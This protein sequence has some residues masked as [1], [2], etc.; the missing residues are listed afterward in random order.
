MWLIDMGTKKFLRHVQCNVKLNLKKMTVFMELK[1][2]TWAKNTLSHPLINTFA[3][4]IHHFTQQIQGYLMN[5]N[6]SI[7]PQMV[8]FLRAGHNYYNSSML[9]N[10]PWTKDRHFIRCLAL[11][12]CLNFRCKLFA[13]ALDSFRQHRCLGA[14]VLHACMTSLHELCQSVL[15]YSEG[16]TWMTPNSTS[17]HT[18]L[19]QG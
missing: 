7:L 10:I 13:I 8:P 16:Q 17:S 15:L 6:N 12:I 1:E 11:N 14:L 18:T 4:N 9:S 3:C 5:A 2:W 19:N